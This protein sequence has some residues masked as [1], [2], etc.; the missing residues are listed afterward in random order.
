MLLVVFSLSF[1]TIIFDEFHLYDAKQLVGLLFYLAYLHVFEFFK[2]G[3]KVVL[4]T[5]TP[6]PACE[7]ALEALA[8]AGVRIARINGE[9]GDQRLPSQTAVELELRSQPETKHDFIQELASE[10]VQHLDAHPD[11]NG[12]VIL[13][14]KDQINRLAD[15]LCAKGL[16]NRFSRITGSTP[17]SDRKWAAQ[18][19]I[20]LATSTVD[21]GF[22]FERDLELNRQNLDWLIFSARDRAAFWQRLGRVGRVLGK[23]KTE[24]PSSAIAYLR[25][26]VW[27]EGLALLDASGGR[28]DLEQKLLEIKSLDRPFLRAYWRSEALL[29]AAQ[30]LLMLEDL[31]EKLP[32]ANLI[33]K[34]FETVRSTL[35]SGRDWKYYQG[36]MRALQAARTIA[37]APK[38]DLQGDPL[39]YIKP[40]FHWHIIA[41]FFRAT[42]PDDWEALRTKQLTVDQ[43][44]QLFRDDQEVAELFKEFA[45]RFNA[46]YAPLFQFRSGL[47]ESLTIRDP[48]GLLLDQ[49][50]QTELDPVH[51][52]RYYDLFNKEL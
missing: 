6:E 19:Q 3:R 49:S 46:S 35:G 13:D 27:E 20:I 12:A 52:L 33:S 51:L 31:M 26:N 7:S 9:T 21:V 18:Q 23:Q 5:A 28:K 39:K 15:L 43:C 11:Q 2:A 25:D 42:S 29:E 38:K 24:I 34:L 1:A 40:K 32:Q 47:F 45:A 10:I 4:L 30:P 41:A 17:K 44:R 48:H 36:R 50:E 37:T 22:N 8:E 14:S 16:R